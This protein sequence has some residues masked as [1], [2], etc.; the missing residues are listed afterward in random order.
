MIKTLRDGL[1]PGPAASARVHSSEIAA[2][3][4][5]RARKGLDPSA[6]RAWLTL[7]AASHR[8]LEEELAH[9]ANER[10]L[11]VA[12]L[13]RSRQRPPSADVRAALMQARL[14][15]RAG[16]YDRKE[17]EELLHAA[18][19]EMARL[20][21]QVAVLEAELLAPRTEPSQP[22]PVLHGITLP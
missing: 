6:V 11:I 21:N 7:V 14:R 3:D 1:A 5:P 10:D 12:S 4:F 15:R 20:E 2:H 22:F 16:G 9:V 13:R 8:N 17:V 18:A 19:E